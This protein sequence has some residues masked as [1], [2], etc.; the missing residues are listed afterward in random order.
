MRNQR[1]AAAAGVA[2][3]LGITASAADA[4]TLYA[5]GF[6]T[7][8]FTTGFVGGQDG[9][10]E[11]PG[12]SASFVENTFAQSG[13]QAVAV[14][15]ALATGQDGPYKTVSTAASIVIQSASIYLASSS[16]QTAW[17]FAAVGSGL[18]GFAGGIDIDADGTIHEI[19]S[20]FGTIGTFARDTW[21]TVSL[22]LNYATQ[23]YSIILNGT[24]LADNVAFCGSNSG[25]TGATVSAYSDGFFDSFGFGPTVND[26]GFLDNYS[27]STPD[28]TPLP[29]ALPLFATGLGGLGLLG[30]RR[31]RKAAALAA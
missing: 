9:W 27:V 29:A 5:T 20:G 2:L 24:T 31:K 17:Q 30:W 12:S 11:Y 6:E 10:S 3:V 19:S 28:T 15:P 21:N 4:A 14:L 13:T 1:Y 25:C 16:T 8:T 23:T 18:S 7:P 26:I 22:D